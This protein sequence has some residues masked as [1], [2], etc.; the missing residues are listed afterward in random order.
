MAKT[1][2]MQFITEAGKTVRLGVDNPKE[3]IEP[4]I[5]KQSMEQIIA[6]NVF[7]TTSGS[8]VSAKSARVVE[9]NVTEYELN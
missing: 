8:F 2:E 6:A 7:F 3:P 1:L 9:R 5:V 4:A